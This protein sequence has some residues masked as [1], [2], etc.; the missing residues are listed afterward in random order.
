MSKTINMPDYMVAFIEQGAETYQRYA[1]GDL[2]KARSLYLDI[3]CSEYIVRRL[4]VL[5]KPDVLSQITKEP[6]KLYKFAT[7]YLQKHSVE[8]EEGEPTDPTWTS[9]EDLIRQESKLQQQRKK[10]N[11]N[12]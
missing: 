4:S 6:E 10:E 3:I 1:D 5:V 2:D 8:F 9:P 11:N 12:V 7:D